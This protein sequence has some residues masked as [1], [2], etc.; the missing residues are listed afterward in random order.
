M[1]GIVH[2][3]SV[4]GTTNFEERDVDPVLRQFAKRYLVCEGF[5]EQAIG[6]LDPVPDQWVTMLLDNIPT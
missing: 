2:I 1:A 3:D 5:I 4:T 6:A